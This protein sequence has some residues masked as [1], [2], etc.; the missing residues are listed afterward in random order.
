M[1]PRERQAK[2]IIYHMASRLGVKLHRAIKLI[3]LVMLR[4]DTHID[5]VV[6]KWQNNDV[7]LSNFNVFI[8]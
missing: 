4:N 7:I 3:D 8:F 2:T 5:N 6:Q 1:A